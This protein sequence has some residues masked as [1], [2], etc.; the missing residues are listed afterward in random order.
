M[1]IRD[2]FTV[3]PKQIYKGHKGCHEW[4]IEFKEAPADL[5]DFTNKLDLALKAVNSDYEA[6][7]HKN[8]ILESPKVH[9]ASN[10]LFFNWMRTRG[11][12]GGQNKVPRL[13][14]K[15]IYLDELLSMNS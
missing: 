11:K 2:R 10:G 14:G 7:R 12:L 15:R 8:L 1:C 4:L 13:S 5:T 3:A 6:K 9:V